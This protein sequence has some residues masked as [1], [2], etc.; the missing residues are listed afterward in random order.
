VDIALSTLLEEPVD[1][2]ERW[3]KKDHSAVEQ[4]RTTGL[5]IDD[6]DGGP[7]EGVVGGDG[8]WPSPS[9]TLVGRDR[10]S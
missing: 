1:D 4:L 10:A 3:Q 2:I 9:V 8:N 7:I 5:E 6:D